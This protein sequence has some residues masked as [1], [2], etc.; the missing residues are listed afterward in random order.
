MLIPWIKIFER[1]GARSFKVYRHLTSFAHHPLH[2]PRPGKQVSTGPDSHQVDVS[3]R[4]VVSAK[5]IMAARGATQ[6]LRQMSDKTLQNLQ[7]CRSAERQTK[8]TGEAENPNEGRSPIS[9]QNAVLQN[10]AKSQTG[11]NG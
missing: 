3:T 9:F 7:H 4:G 6:F 5:G 11:I 10:K 1:R 2:M 8:K